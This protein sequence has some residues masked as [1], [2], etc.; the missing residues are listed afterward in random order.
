VGD[1]A[2]Y[3]GVAGAAVPVVEGDCGGGGVETIFGQRRQAKSGSSAARR[4][5]N[6]KGDNFI[7]TND[8]YFSR[9]G[10]RG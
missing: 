7:R 9:N 6:L 4:M 8:D 1:G 3:T 5:T 2:A 10:F